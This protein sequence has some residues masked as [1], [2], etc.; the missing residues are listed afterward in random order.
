MSSTIWTPDELLSSA[1]RLG[2]ECWRI[3]ESQSRGSTLKL[4]DTLD[5]QHTLESLI[6][7]TKPPIPDGCAALHYL[8]FTPF[9]YSPYKHSSRFRRS[10]FS[11]GVFY[12]AEASETAVA[13]SVFYRLLFFSESPTTPWPANPID[14]RA[15]AAV[16]NTDL[17]SDLT[18]V[19]L[20][21]Q[22]DD[23]THPTDYTACLNFSDLARAAGI[24]V[25]RYQSVRD[26]SHRGN[27]ALLT[28]KVLSP[29]QT[30]RE[31]TWL[32]HFGKSG[33]RAICESPRKSLAFD[34][35]TFAADPRT[36]T[37][38]WER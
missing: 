34:A 2:G 11:E 28:P 24:E 14:H 7:A 6:E 8:L 22:R 16:F 5:E 35:R 23:W 19:P 33:V 15:F 17:A 1:V 13:E 29:D 36:A 21:A 26:P 27:L 12:G 20:A 9:R 32:F 10:G 38:R 30:F 18:I 25:I 3:V 37:W 4:T 31:E